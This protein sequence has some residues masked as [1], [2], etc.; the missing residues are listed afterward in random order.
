MRVA[1]LLVL[2]AVGLGTP[3][4]AQTPPS[5]PVAPAAT[6]TQPPAPPP[7]PPDTWLP[8]PGADLAALDKITAKVTPLVGK[9][10]QAMKF[11]S[12]SVTVRSCIV[13]G[14]DQPAD[15]AAFLDVTDS[16][17]AGFAFHGW[18]IL[19]DPAASMMQHPVY[20]LRL[21]GCRG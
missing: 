14:P 18:V 11:G 2:A 10:G 15:Q 3:V 5:Q 12:L 13:R 19:S 6:T 21:I 9:I 7:P 20:D 8:K 17:D 4:M 1:L 16:R